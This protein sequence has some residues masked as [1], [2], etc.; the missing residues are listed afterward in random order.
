MSR[1]IFSNKEQAAKIQ[2]C[3]DTDVFDLDWDN[4]VVGSRPDIGIIAEKSSKFDRKNPNYTGFYDW[5][6]PKA[7]NYTYPHSIVLCQQQNLC[8][9][10]YLRKPL[11]YYSFLSCIGIILFIIIFVIIALLF[12]L[13]KN[14]INILRRLGDTFIIS[15]SFIIVIGLIFKFIIKSNIYFINISNVINVIFNQFLVI[16]MVFY[17]CGII[18]YLGYYL[19]IKSV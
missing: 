19:I 12:V 10:N 4:V 14:K 7:A 6:T 8:W 16:S 13:E 9:D 18:S 11:I 15:G 2:E 5:Y 1:I 3:F 17:I